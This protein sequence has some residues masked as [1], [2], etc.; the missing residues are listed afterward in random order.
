MRVSVFAS[1]SLLLIAL[2]FGLTSPA[3]AEDTEM[4][5]G[6]TPVPPGKYPWQVRL[7]ETMDDTKGFCGGSIVGDSWVLTAGHCAVD[8]DE[9]VVGFGSVDR[10]KT[11]KRVS[12]KIIVHPGYI[13]GQKADLALIKLKTPISNSPWIG[14]ADADLDRSLLKPG[15]S[16]TVSGWGATWDTGVFDSYVT[17][18]TERHAKK[19]LHSD[20]ELQ[21]PLKLH[22]VEIKVVDPQE[23]KEAFQAL[24][25]TEWQIGD[26]EIC[27]TEP[28]G[29]KDSCYGDSG[30]PLMVPTDNIKGFVQVGIVSWGPQCG[31]PNYPG[32]YTRLSSFNDWIKTTM[33]NN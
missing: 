31:N 17:Y 3:A 7:Y 25:I 1:Q 20:E 16:V 28:A 23:C 24:N 15:A 12:E 9:I 30:G 32:V 19:V 14:V 21:F 22:E 10:T 4:I 26:T 2:S 18:I 6:G 5:V 11:V 33:K 27:A 8:M 29:G 13:A